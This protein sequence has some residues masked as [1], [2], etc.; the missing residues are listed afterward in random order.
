MS[1]TIFLTA[2]RVFCTVGRSIVARTSS[3]NTV[4]L[5]PRLYQCS[6]PFSTRRPLRSAID[7]SLPFVTRLQEVPTYGPANHTGTVNRRLIDPVTVGSHAIELLHGTLS[8]T[9]T[10]KARAAP[11]YH[12]NMDQVCYLLSGRALCRTLV[13]G[14]P[15]ES[16]AGTDVWREQIIEKGDACFFAR[17]VVHEVIALGG[18]E[19][20]E[21]GKGNKDGEGKVQVLVIYSPPYME[22][23]ANKTVVWMGKMK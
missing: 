6:R 20:L 12:P 21:A 17:G 2:S 19:V 16:L 7:P 10:D 11:H 23:P 5:S 3:R 15:G 1:A 14:K 4:S 22:D 9:G 8:A 13:P 18:D